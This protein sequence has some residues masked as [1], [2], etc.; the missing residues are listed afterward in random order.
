MIDDI[1]KNDETFNEAIFLSRVDH[2]FIMLLDSIL[3][4]DVRNVKHYLS[5]EIFNKFNDL[6]N[7]YKQRNVTRIFDET[8]VKS[9]EIIDSYVSNNMINVVVKLTSRYMDYII[10]ENGNY[11]SG[12]NT[13]R[14]EKE[15]TI[16]F[17]KKLDSK[18]LKEAR[19]CIHCGKTLDINYSGICPYC[20]EPTDMSDFDYI[21]TQIDLL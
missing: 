2:I 10:D 1:K 17:S 6:V 19:R 8:N 13:R 21:I 5:E 11:I 4:N 20:K 9:T 16:V 15:H 12:N 18:E 14:I 7:S 3:E